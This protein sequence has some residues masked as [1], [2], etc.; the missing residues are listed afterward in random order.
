MK[1]HIFLSISLLFLLVITGC[2]NSTRTSGQD[3][4]QIGLVSPVFPPVVGPGQIKI[5]ILDSRG[6]PVDDL[7]LEVKGD[8][9]HAGMVPELA[10]ADQSTNGIY[11]VPFDWTMAGDWIVTVE[12][13]DHNGSA[14]QRRFE[15]SV[16][17]EVPIC[18]DPNAS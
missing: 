12:A 13:A 5:E 14:A 2:R 9:T 8:M 18:N 10:S 7:R 16:D 15:F 6:E 11:I 17:G 3:T 1:Q 4:V